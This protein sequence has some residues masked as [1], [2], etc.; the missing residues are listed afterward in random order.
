[1]NYKKSNIFRIIREKRRQNEREFVTLLF[2]VLLV[3]KEEKE[4]IRNEKRRD[5]KM[6]NFLSS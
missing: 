2:C 3:G 1:M 6:N 4:M 5:S